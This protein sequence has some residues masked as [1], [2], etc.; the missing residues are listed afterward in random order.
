[1][2]QR[3]EASAPPLNCSVCPNACSCSSRALAILRSWLAHQFL[4]SWQRWH[5]ARAML[6]AELTAEGADL[7]GISSLRP[8]I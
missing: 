1:M 8:Y 7:W 4:C 2:L 6:A 5:E 3:H